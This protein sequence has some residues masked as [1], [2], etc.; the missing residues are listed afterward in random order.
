MLQAEVKSLCRHKGDRVSHDTTFPT[1]P[2]A[3]FSP[4]EGCTG[5]L[6]YSQGCEGCHFFLTLNCEQRAKSPWCLVLTSPV[7]WVT[8]IASLGLGCLHCKMGIFYCFTGV[9][10]SS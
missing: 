10:G 1:S 4:A 7:T 9:T 6:L 5:C 8:C 3:A 2:Q